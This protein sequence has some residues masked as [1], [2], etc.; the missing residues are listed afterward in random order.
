[1]KTQAY[2]IK[3]YLFRITLALLCLP[4]IQYYTNLIYLKKLNG[5]IEKIENPVLNQEKWMNGSYAEEMGKYLTH[6]FGFRNIYVKLDNQLSFSLF[7]EVH[8]KNI[9]VGKEDYLY[10]MNYINAY[11]GK[12]FIGE[13]N[14]KEKVK[15][16][17]FIQETL[18]K[19]E[20]YLLIILAAGKASFYPEYIP[21]H[22]MLNTDSTN[23]LFYKKELI[24]QKV[25][26]IDFNSW[27]IENKGKMKYPL[28]PKTGIHWSKYGLLLAADSIIEHID[29]IKE[30]DIPELYW[31]SIEYVNILRKPD[32]DIELAMNLILPFSN[33]KMGYPQI[34]FN[35]KGKDRPKVIVISDS[36]FWGIYNAGITKKVFNKGEFWYY[37]KT[38]YQKHLNTPTKV[39]TLNLNKKISDK[40]IVIMMATEANLKY[41]P[42]GADKKLFKY[43]NGKYSSEKKI[44]NNM[45]EMKK[46]EIRTNKKWLNHIKEKAIKKGISLDSMIHLDAIYVLENKH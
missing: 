10:E 4:I 35:N 5:D 30:W 38:V 25:N 17:K 33:F 8:A 40:D 11:T 7:G 44:T 18:A 24:E 6:N 14:I 37:Y 13:R 36:F 19:Q 1:M 39:S 15:K 28:Y 32:N 34:K 22:L 3:K 16:L 45:I 41:F 2:T 42:W 29:N 26:H 46:Q 23:Y 21:D 20:K 31:D 27:F 12:D 43:C 9:V